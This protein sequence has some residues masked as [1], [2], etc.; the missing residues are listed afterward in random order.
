LY[1]GAAALYALRGVLSIVIVPVAVVLRI[2][3]YVLGCAERAQPQSA[4]ALDQF[5]QGSICVT[6]KTGRMKVTVDVWLHCV[7]AAS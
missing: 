3:V 7:E 2:K 1:R 5:F 4:T 6:G